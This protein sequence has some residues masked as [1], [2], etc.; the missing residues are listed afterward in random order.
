M[1]D[2]LLRWASI[3]A[4]SVVVSGAFVLY[5]LVFGDV[6]SPPSGGVEVVR[7][8][9]RI[10]THPLFL[11]GLVLAFTGALLRMFLFSYVGIAQTAMVSEFTL[12]LSVALATVVFDGSPNRQEYV[13][14]LLIMAGVY[15]VQSTGNVV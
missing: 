8:F 3:L 2:L 12:V 11:A 15:L 7:Y 9:A 5:G 14:M 6:G 13:G 4:F 1:S 10:A